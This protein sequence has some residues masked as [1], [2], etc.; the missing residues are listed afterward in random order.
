MNTNAIIDVATTGF[1]NS[2]I[3][4]IGS[5]TRRSHQMKTPRTASPPTIIRRMTVEL[6]AYSCPPHVAARMSSITDVTIM[7]APCQSM[8]W[9]RFTCGMRSARFV[10]NSATMPIGRLTVKIHRHVRLSTK[11]PPISGPMIDESANTLVKNPV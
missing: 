7:T 5:G 9:S 8:R 11:N 1:A 3:G 2:R 4:T 6:H 10:T